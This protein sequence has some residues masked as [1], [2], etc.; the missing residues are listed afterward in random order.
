[1]Q[2]SWG[3]ENKQPTP[4]RTGELHGETGTWYVNNTTSIPDVFTRADPGV[5]GGDD[6]STKFHVKEYVRKGDTQA[7]TNKFPSEQDIQPTGLQAG[8][9]A[10]PDKMAMA[11][12]D[13][14]IVW[15]PPKGEESKHSKF[16]GMVKEPKMHKD[17]VGG[18][19]VG[20][21]GHVPRSRDKVGACPLGGVVTGRSDSGFPA[22]S[23]TAP[24]ALPGF[25]AQ[26]SHGATGE[27][28]LFVTVANAHNTSTVMAASGVPPPNKPTATVSGDGF[29]PKYAGHKPKTYD[30]IGSSVYGGQPEGRKQIAPSTFEFRT[31]HGDYTLERPTDP[32]HGRDIGS[33]RPYLMGKAGKHLAR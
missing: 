15:P 13:M 10:H 20:Y 4:C 6:A 23:A 11:D 19:I 29:I 8:M 32:L 14:G 17:S 12:H 22:A 30:N 1:M 2:A 3:Q 9:F 27:H 25:G 5:R 7:Y 26:T 18:I 16:M 33:V 28:P 31:I 21:K 24:N